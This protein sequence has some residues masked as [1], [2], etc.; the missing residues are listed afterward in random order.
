MNRAEV[1]HRFRPLELRRLRIQQQHS[2]LCLT[3]RLQSLISALLSI[4]DK[5]SLFEGSF[6]RGNMSKSYALDPPWYVFPLA[7][8]LSLQ[9]NI[10]VIDSIP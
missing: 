10:G 9:A 2:S 4:L 7:I 8:P 5:T 3:W 1:V 6:G